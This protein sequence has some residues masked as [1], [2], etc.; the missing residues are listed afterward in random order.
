ML[1]LFILQNWKF[2]EMFWCLANVNLVIPKQIYIFI[3]QIHIKYAGKVTML[4]ASM[5]NALLQNKYI[6]SLRL[7]L[8]IRLVLLL[9]GHLQRWP[10]SVLNTLLP[11][12]R[13]LRVRGHIHYT[14]KRADLSNAGQKKSI[15]ITLITALYNLSATFIKP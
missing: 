4:L 5:H 10:K 9:M 15:D 7:I 13:P 12:L 8:T 14:S 11:F 1:H 2:S 3:L 6:T